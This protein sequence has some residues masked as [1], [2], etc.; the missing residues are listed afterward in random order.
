MRLLRF[1]KSKNAWVQLFSDAALDRYKN[2]SDL[3]D[4][5]AARDNLELD[6]YYWNKE[7]LKNGTA[8]KAI[9][10]VCII[11]D[12]KAQFISQ[13][14]RE[15]WDQKV[16]RPIVSASMP[17]KITEGQL[18]YNPSQDT[19]LVKINGNMRDLDNNRAA[20]G[21]AKFSGMGNET[22][23]AH[24]LKTMG[25]NKITPKFVSFSCVTN[26]Q[27]ELGETWFRKDDTNI[28]IGNTGS[29]KGVFEYMI[30]Y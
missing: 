4:K 23:I 25:G 18:L 21:R 15:N 16:D 6:T 24:N 30:H 1:D 10:N 29:Y 9:H 17:A 14:D 13:K 22:V 8:V 12:D 11:Q 20:F 26:P 5:K 3:T 19:L 7:S 28:Y 2:L 27:G